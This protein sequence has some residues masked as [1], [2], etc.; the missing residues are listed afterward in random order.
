M[1]TNNFFKQAGYNV[2]N[3]IQMPDINGSLKF[4]IFAKVLDPDSFLNH[5][6]TFV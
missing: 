3:L 1:T 4:K 5:D 2:T 6:L